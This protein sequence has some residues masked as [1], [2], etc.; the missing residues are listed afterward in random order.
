MFQTDPIPVKVYV[1]R[2]YQK[3]G[4]PDHILSIIQTLL[5]KQVCPVKPPL[6]GEVTINIPIF[7]KWFERHGYSIPGDKIEMLRNILEEDVKAKFRTA[8]VNE[9]ESSKR[10]G[11][12]LKITPVIKDTM[13]KYGLT[14]DDFAFET[15]KKDLQRYCERQSIDY[16][17]QKKSGRSVPKNGGFSAKSA[18]PDLVPLK[19]YLNHRGV[20]RRTFF[21]RYRKLWPVVIV[22]HNTFIDTSRPIA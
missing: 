4:Y 16:Q 12:K 9:I 22:N 18:N 1:A 2:F 19:E 7:Q 8:L 3:N 10:N 21:R 5:S 20:S 15:I 13:E 11:F 6:S 14:D 17:E